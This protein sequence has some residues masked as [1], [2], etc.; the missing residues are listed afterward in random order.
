MPGNGHKFGLN[1]SLTSNQRTVNQLDKH[2]G[3]AFAMY[4]YPVNSH[5]DKINIWH[6]SWTYTF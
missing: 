2:Y 3:I 5:M 4:V 6:R 1:D